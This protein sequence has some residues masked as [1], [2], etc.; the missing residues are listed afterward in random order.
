MGASKYSSSQRWEEDTA[1]DD[2]NDDL[3]SQLWEQDDW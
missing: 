3:L 1:I 2:Y